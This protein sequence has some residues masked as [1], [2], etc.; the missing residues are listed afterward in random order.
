[1][2]SRIE[3]RPS[4]PQKVTF[5]TRVSRVYTLLTHSSGRGP[6]LAYSQI[7]M[8]LMGLG[9]EKGRSRVWGG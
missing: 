7:E 8:T 9:I 6:T 3:M 4:R 2:I 5:R 1:M